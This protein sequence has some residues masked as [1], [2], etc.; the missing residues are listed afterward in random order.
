MAHLQIFN[1]TDGKSYHGSASR[2]PKIG[3]CIGLM[4]EAEKIMVVVRAVEA[5]TLPDFVE[6]YSVTVDMVT[7]SIEIQAKPRKRA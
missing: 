6:A 5:I 2:P 7:P 4:G 1:Q 3:E